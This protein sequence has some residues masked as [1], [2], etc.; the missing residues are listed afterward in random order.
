VA[1]CSLSRC[2]LSQCFKSS[3]QEFF[4]TPIVS[5]EECQWKLNDVR[6]FGSPVFVLHKKLQ[7]GDSYPKWQARSW[8]GAYIGHSTYHATNI[9]LIYNPSLTHVS[10]PQYQIVF[11]EHFTSIS[12]PLSDARV[13]FLEQLYHTK[14]WIKSSSY[15]NTSEEYHFDD[16]WYNPPTISPEG[17]TQ[18]KRK[19]TSTSMQR[20]QSEGVG[21]RFSPKGTPLTTT[22]SIEQTLPNIAPPSGP[23]TTGNSNDLSVP[24]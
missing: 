5:G 18:N 7:D 11:N 16:F 14:K 9:S 22:P 23:S 20:T 24:E 19:R 21:E 12:A 8:Q 1:F 15:T 3:R 17:A 4:S 2:D 13:I 10:P 6:I